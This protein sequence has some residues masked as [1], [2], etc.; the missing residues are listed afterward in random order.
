MRFF[1]IFVACLLLNA[2][3]KAPYT[4]IP[5]SGRI[6]AFGDSLTYGY[7]VQASQSYP[8]VLARLS[9]R[10]VV[11]AGVSG[12]I[13]ANGL[14]RLAE[15]LE[16][17]RY[18]FLIL[19]EGGND[20][21]QNLPA[22][23]TKE[24]LAAMLELANQYHLPVLLIA[25]PEKSVLAKAAPFYQELADDYQVPL[26]KSLAG[27]LLKQAKYKSDS[28]HFN[29]AG[30]EAMAESINSTMKKLGAL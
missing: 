14:L 24:N 3:G 21:L 10:E 5:E 20:I 22:H 2:C 19:L 8:A 25:V 23:Q 6:L 27:D 16:E 28:V 17:D 26:V 13:T 30:Y 12:E 29:A 18:D 9:R 15:L 1:L 11:N 4:T 7:N